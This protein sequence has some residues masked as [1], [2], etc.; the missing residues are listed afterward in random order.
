MTR[1]IAYQ[2]FELIARR[3]AKEVQSLSRTDLREL[4]PSNGACVSLRL[5]ERITQ[6]VY[7]RQR[8]TPIQC[9]PLFRVAVRLIGLEPGVGYPGL[10][11]RRRG[12][13][14]HP[15]PG[16]EQHRSGLAAHLALGASGIRT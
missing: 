13:E 15:P 3:R 9:E 14:L 8:K 5:N 12:Q 1:S 6:T 10:G 2:R 7:Y 16:A 11:R 4:S